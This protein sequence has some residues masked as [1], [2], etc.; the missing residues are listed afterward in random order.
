MLL[1][2]FYNKNELFKIQSTHN[3]YSYNIDQEKI[4]IYS[5]T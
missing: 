4:F 2:I 1:Y 3:Y 5:E